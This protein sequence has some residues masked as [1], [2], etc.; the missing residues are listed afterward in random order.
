MALSRRISV[1]LCAAWR[2]L[3][4]ALCPVAL[5]G[6]R[7]PGLPLWRFQFRKRHIGENR[8]EVSIFNPGDAPVAVTSLSAHGMGCGWANAKPLPNKKSSL[9]F[10][11]GGG[12]YKPSVSRPWPVRSARKDSITTNQDNIHSLVRVA[13]G[14]A[15][16][17]RILHG[18]LA[19]GRPRRLRFLFLRDRIKGR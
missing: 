14:A 13:I 12:H 9:S 2:F 7:F 6:R 8:T 19:R 15:I 1:A 10:A 4:G 11:L 17:H 18:F 5:P 3:G 16:V